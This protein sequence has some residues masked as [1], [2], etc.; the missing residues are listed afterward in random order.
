MYHQLLLWLQ[1][2]A[3]EAG[4]LS[5]K[6]QTQSTGT[7]TETWKFPQEWKEKC[8]EGPVKIDQTYVTNLLIP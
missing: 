4:H 1:L 8:T 7:T 3:S 5:Y 6:Q 2:S